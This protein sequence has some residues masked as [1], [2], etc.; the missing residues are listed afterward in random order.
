MRM[1]VGAALAVALAAGFIQ[2]ASAAWSHTSLSKQITLGGA[3]SMFSL[4]AHAVPDKQED[5]YVLYLSS[6]EHARLSSISASAKATGNSVD[7]QP[8]LVGPLNDVNVTMAYGI[9]IPPALQGQELDISV[10]GR[11]VHASQPL[12]YAIRQGEAQLLYWSG[13]A[14]VRT[15]YPSK[16]ATLTIKAPTAKIEAFGPGGTQSGSSITY[17]PAPRRAH[18]AVDL[19]PTTFVHYEYPRPVVTYVD[20]ER[21]VQVSHIGNTVSTQDNVWMRNDGALLN[22]FFSRSEYLISKYLKNNAES[23]SMIDQVAYFLPAD[24]RDIYFVDTIGNV[25]TSTVQPSATGK[26]TRV[27]L[28]PRYPLLGGWNYTY[29][30]GWNEDLNLMARSVSLGRTIFE[31]PFISVT[32]NTAVDHARARIVLPEGA[33][34]IDVALPFDADSVRIERV[35]TYLDTVGRPAVVIERNKCSSAHNLPVYIEYSLSPVDYLRKPI[36]VAV[37]V[38]ALFSVVSVL[39]RVKLGVPSKR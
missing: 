2:A 6:E 16:Q 5:R 33:H 24:A 25:S 18:T 29:S 4:E 35:S 20:L 36:A 38:A 1:R 37:A 22:G 39:R 13:D 26:F 15:P 8:R 9:D 14:A 27:N 3:T 21:N 31:V 30:L 23:S 28:Q 12:P 19:V 17:G 7:V 34:N 11:L 32:K 10:S